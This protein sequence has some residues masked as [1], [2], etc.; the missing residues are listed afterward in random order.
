MSV[1]V[2]TVPMTVVPVT[3]VPVQYRKLSRL[4]EQV[5]LKEEILLVKETKVTCLLDISW[6]YSNTASIQAEQMKLVLNNTNNR[7]NLDY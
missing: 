7:P 2:S 6:N 1:P 5:F 3:T 4:E